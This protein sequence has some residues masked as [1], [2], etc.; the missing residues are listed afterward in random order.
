MTKKLKKKLMD[1]LKYKN[2]KETILNKNGFE[3]KNRQKF[4]KNIQTNQNFA[5]KNKTS[6]RQL[7]FSSY[8]TS[9]SVKQP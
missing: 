5:N 7:K 6:L 9:L 2:I 4:S 3:S 1:K 8:Q